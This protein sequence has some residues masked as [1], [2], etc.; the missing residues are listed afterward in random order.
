MSTFGIEYRHMGTTYFIPVPAAKSFEDAENHIR[1]A[2]FN[3]EAQEV[4]ASMPVPG[5]M[6]KAFGWKQ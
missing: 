6:G 5:W 2:R 1:S 3:G 4:V